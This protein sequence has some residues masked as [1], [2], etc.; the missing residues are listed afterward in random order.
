MER[1]RGC[2]L[3]V[4]SVK[5]ECLIG[6]LYYPRINQCMI[7]SARFNE[8]PQRLGKVRWKNPLMLRR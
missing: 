4:N 6:F 3:F 7:L 2:H 8:E 5:E 1:V